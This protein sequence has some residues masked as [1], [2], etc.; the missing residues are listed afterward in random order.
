MTDNREEL[1]NLRLAI[2]TFLE[3]KLAGEVTDAGLFVN[4]PMVADIEVAMGDSKYKIEI[5]EL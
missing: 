1:F 5:K 3:E 2:Q 4:V